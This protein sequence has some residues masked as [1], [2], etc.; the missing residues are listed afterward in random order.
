MSYVVKI[1]NDI[2][3]TIESTGGVYTYEANNPVVNYNLSVTR[4]EQLTPDAQVVKHVTTHLSYAVTSVKTDPAYPDGLVF[5]T[6]DYHDFEVGQYLTITNLPS[7][8]LYSDLDRFNGRQYISHRIET[9]DGFSKKF[10][11]YKD[12]CLKLY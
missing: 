8:G 11:V 7:S 4:G 12:K 10:V 3:G 2:T 9:D 5:T 1:I 6:V